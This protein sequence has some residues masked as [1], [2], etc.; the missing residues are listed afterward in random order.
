LIVETGIRSLEMFIHK[1]EV[2]V[3]RDGKEYSAYY[4]VEGS[5]IFLSANFWE[6]RTQLGSSPAKTLASMLLCEMIDGGAFEDT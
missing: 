2:T 4:H 1:D 6:M 5:T 3:Q